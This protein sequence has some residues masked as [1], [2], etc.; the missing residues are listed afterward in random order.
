MSERVPNS[1][2]HGPMFAWQR[3]V[4]LLLM[5]A[6]SI[7]AGYFAQPLVAGNQAVISIVVTV[8]S[9]LAGFLVAVITLLGDPR[10]E[11]WKALQLGKRELEARLRRHR[12]LFYLYLATLGLA[13]AT[14]LVPP[15]YVS[16]KVWFERFFV[17]FTVF[18][19][20]ASFSLPSA[21][22]RLQMEKYVAEL[23]AKTP[24][25]L[26]KPDDKRE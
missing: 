19:F 11:G 6:V 9:I 25:Y 10:G 18:V 8:F 23:D 1:N 15:E 16:V 22:S 24:K 21:L 14:L 4:V 20:L 26:R 3:T 12:F 7:V 13:L 5:A 2:S 17:G